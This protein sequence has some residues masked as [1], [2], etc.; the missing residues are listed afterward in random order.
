MNVTEDGEV[1]NIPGRIHESVS[2]NVETFVMGRK[3]RYPDKIQAHDEHYHNAIH[4]ITYSPLALVLEITIA[5]CGV[6]SRGEL[7]NIHNEPH[8]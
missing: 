3:T 6:T 1:P 8:V 2:F 7:N 5:R 4:A